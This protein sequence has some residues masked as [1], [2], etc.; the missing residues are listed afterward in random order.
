MGGPKKTQEK[1]RKGKSSGWDTQLR[2]HKH[3]GLKAKGCVSGFGKKRWQPKV[4]KCNLK[5][6]KYKSRAGKS[7]GWEWDFPQHV[8]GWESRR[9]F[10]IRV[11]LVS[12]RRI[13]ACM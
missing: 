9:Y 1:T 5:N 8:V 2:S 13:S 6:S 10:R 12:W 4:A 7:V 3:M 11:A